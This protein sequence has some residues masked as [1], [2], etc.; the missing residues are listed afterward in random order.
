MNILI[1]ISENFMNPAKVM[2][3]SLAQH[4][5]NLKIYIIYS[6]LTEVQI[7]DLGDYVHKLL[8]AELIPVYAGEVF[9]DVPLSEQYAKPELYYRLQAPYVLPEQIDRILYLDADM[10][11][12]GNLDE[13]YQQDM[14]GAAIAVMKDRF[15]FC[16]DV[17]M[18]KKRLELTEED[19]YFNSGVILFDL[20]AFRKYIT[21]KNIL[22]I[23][24]LKRE[25]L[26]FFDQDI[27]NILMRNH[28][29]ICNEKYNFQAYPFEELTPN[30]IEDMLVVHFTDL[31]KP[32]N[33]NYT[34]KLGGL[35]WENAEKAGI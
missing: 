33:D 19:V 1:T 32:W 18:Q 15:D 24:R 34:G 23:I 13:F 17:V 20:K 16:E 10:I 7:E 12:R 21:L 29:K 4:N 25:V 6:S 35:F 3:F 8:G 30:D 31:P 26:K 14:L 2:L 9:K 5:K 22:D 11:I 28:K 27:L